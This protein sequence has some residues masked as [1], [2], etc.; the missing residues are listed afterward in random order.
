MIYERRRPR[1]APLIV[2]SCER[3]DE[4]W[5]SDA[6]AEQIWTTLG[7]T[8]ARLD[9]LR[10]DMALP[11]RPTWRPWMK[12]WEGRAAWKG[13]AANRS[14]PDPE[15]SPEEVQHRIAKVQARWTDETYYLRAMGRA[16]PLPYQFPMYSTP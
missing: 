2:V 14:P 1:Q 3:L 4:L 8:R 15:V 5:K 11:K 13:K 7:I 10:I 6:T 12:P 16:R 9:T